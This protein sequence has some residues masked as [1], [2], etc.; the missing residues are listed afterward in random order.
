MQNRIP[1]KGWEH[2]SKEFPNNRT[3]KTVVYPEDM[4]VLRNVSADAEANII[5]LYFPAM[6]DK[7]IR[8]TI[9]EKFAAPPVCG[10]RCA[11]CKHYAAFFI[12]TSYRGGHIH[13]MRQIDEGRCNRARVPGKRVKGTGVC[14]HWKD[15]NEES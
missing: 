5:F 1:V 8:E 7:T 3:Y 10:R 14:E 12:D 15:K 9:D 11:T 4:R 2:A 13:T 6:I